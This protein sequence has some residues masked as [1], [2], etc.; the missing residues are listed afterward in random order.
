MG[1]KPTMALIPADSEIQKAPKIH[2]DTLLCIF[3]SSLR[4][5][6]SGALL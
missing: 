3:L 1:V 5:Y 6:A 4:E 2:K